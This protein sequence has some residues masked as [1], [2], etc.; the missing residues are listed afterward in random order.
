[1]GP[2]KDGVILVIN[3]AKSVLD[4]ST[5]PKEV[6]DICKADLDKSITDISG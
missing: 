4:A 3:F 5:L 6:K 2:D 1:M